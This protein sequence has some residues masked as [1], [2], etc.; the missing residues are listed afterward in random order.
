[1]P[2]KSRYR[3]SRRRR[4]RGTGSKST[5]KYVLA[6][7]PSPLGRKF[8]ALLRYYEKGL[9][10]NPG[11]AGAASQYVF[12]ANGV[13]DPNITGTGHQPLGFDQLMPLYDHATVIGSKI[14]IT[15]ENTDTTYAQILSLHM[16]DNTTTVT[17]QEILI[18]NGSCKYTIIN[19]TAAGGSTK[20]LSM[21]AN[22][23]K[24]LGRSH[25]LSEDDLQNTISSNPLEQCYWV[26]SAQPNS[27]SDTNL[28][29]F[30]VL[31]EYMTVFFEPKQLAQS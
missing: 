2:R 31:L 15:A 19:N 7:N 12:S 25:P 4:R 22:P 18:E 20:I 1:M 10:L 26:V 11:V 27:A 9:S 30:S 14:T 13:Y 6:K 24:F 23:N 29:Y 5:S 28:V 16:Q 8:K 21:K 17:N 3:K